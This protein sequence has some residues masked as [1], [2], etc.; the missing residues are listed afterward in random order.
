MATRAHLTS[1]HRDLCNSVCICFVLE[2]VRQI[3]EWI[4]KILPW[5]GRL[6][7]LATK[8][9]CTSESRRNT[10]VDLILS[11]NVDFLAE[12][13][14]GCAG[15][16]GDGYRAAACVECVM[17][18]RQPE[19]FVGLAQLPFLA[20]RFLYACA[21]LLNI[22]PAELVREVYLVVIRR[23]ER[24]KCSPG[25]AA[26]ILGSRG[27]VRFDENPRRCGDSVKRPAKH[28]V[29]GPRVDRIHAER[30]GL[31]VH[32]DFVV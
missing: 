14:A 23:I 12:V 26:R 7:K 15:V 8:E 20:D 2:A 29:S 17:R 18:R 21:Y 27:V 25:M 3:H 16:R 24:I 1:V 30:T 13:A 5:R 32:F 19:A 22:F 6:Q 28:P 11:T 31:P 4:G 10:F 9:S